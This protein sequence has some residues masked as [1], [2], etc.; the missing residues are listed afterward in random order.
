MRARRPRRSLQ[1]ALDVLPKMAPDMLKPTP[2]NSHRRRR[3]AA[4]A[5]DRR[6]LTLARR[7]SR[8]GAAARHRTLGD[9]T[10]ELR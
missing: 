7:E 8:L 4:P 2:A 9:T 3:R 6:A 5:R 10:Y 1:R